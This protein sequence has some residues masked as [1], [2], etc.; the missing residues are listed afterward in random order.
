MIGNNLALAPD[1]LVVISPSQKG[2]ELLFYEAR[3]MLIGGY[4]G[5]YAFIRVG[6]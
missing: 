5:A 1:P 6:E 4:E 3:L 2:K